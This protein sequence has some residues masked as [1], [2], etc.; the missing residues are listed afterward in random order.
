MQHCLTWRD[1]DGLVHAVIDDTWDGRDRPYALML[2]C[3]LDQTWAH[4][5]EDG[6]FGHIESGEIRA[7]NARE[8]VTCMICVLYC[9]DP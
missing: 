8:V 2:A 4:G 7:A 6:R 5:L 3:F 1:R 9:D